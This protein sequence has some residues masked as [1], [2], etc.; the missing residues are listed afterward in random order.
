MSV[1]R[2]TYRALDAVKHFH[3]L[4]GQV[5]NDL[6][7][8]EPVSRAVALLR[9]RLICEEF[10]EV[11]I[12]LHEGDLVKFVDGL[13]DLLY[14]LY[15]SAVSYGTPIPDEFDYQFKTKKDRTFGLPDEYDALRCAWGLSEMVSEACVT[16]RNAVVSCNCESPRCDRQTVTSQDYK[17]LQEV[18]HKAVRTVCGIANLNHLPLEEVFFEV[19]RSNLSKKLGGATNGRKYGE[20][21]GKGPGYTPPDVEGILQKARLNEPTPSETRQ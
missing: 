5:I 21:G 2:E 19:H 1:K 10:A 16:L 13:A 8:A 4:N 11:M 15:G 14:V 12:A 20:G 17:D 7:P 9:S 18:L 6:P 3:Q